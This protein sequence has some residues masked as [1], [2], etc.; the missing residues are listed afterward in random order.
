MTDTPPPDRET[1][2]RKRQGNIGKL[3]TLA[4][5]DFSDRALVKLRERGYPD[6]TPFHTA[7]ISNLDADGTRISVLAERANMS[8]QAMSQIVG[9]LEKAD[10]VRRAPD[11]NDGRATLIHF[12]DRGWDFLEVAYAIKTEIEAEYMA[13]VGEDGM[14]ELARLLR[15]ILNG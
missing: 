15:V 1:I 14:T 8:K 13:L 12:T 9:E 6:M 5:R 10:I 3:F 4:A 2:I 7:L 11:P